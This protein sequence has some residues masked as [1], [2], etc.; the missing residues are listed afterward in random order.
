MYSL[1]QFAYLAG[2][3]ALAGAV[4]AYGVGALGTRSSRTAP[5]RG[6][7]RG[8]L[9]GV[10]TSLV[11]G[12]PLATTLTVSSFTFLAACLGFRWVAAGHGPFAN[13]YEFSIAFAW[14]AVGAYLLVERRYGLQMLSLFV[15]PVALA[16]LLYAGTLPSEIA[17]L[18]PALQNDVLLTL[19]VAGA[20]AA[21]GA[22]AVAFGAALLYLVQDAT[23]RAWLPSLATLDEVGY[24]AVTVGFPM[25]AL[26]LLLGALWAEIAW[27]SYWSWDAKETATL[28]T[29]L[30]YGGYL[31]ARVVPGWRGRRSA[32]LLV[33]GFAAVLFTYFG[34]YFLGGQHGYA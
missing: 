10:S 34:N 31:H 28:V 4:A 23:H 2:L 9:G 1:S 26:V 7:A 32:L 5:P 17:P 12:S 25:M 11:A 6:P 24:R 29:W 18:V 16:M 3:I 8:E 13:M 19:H 21:Y 15:L 20:V 22:F 27:G 14:A 30:L 33:L